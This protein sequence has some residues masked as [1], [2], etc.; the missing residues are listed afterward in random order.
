MEK[1]KISKILDNHKKWLNDEDGGVRANLSNAHLSRADLSGAK[2]LLKTVNYMDSN[3]ERTT[4][5]YIAYKTF[6]GQYKPPVEWKI[7]SGAVISENVNFNRCLRASE[8]N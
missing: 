2:G 4:N 1:S 7:E 6:G 3:F 8:R 5:G